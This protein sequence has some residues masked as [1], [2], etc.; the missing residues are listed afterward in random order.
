MAS[1][2][3]KLQYSVSSSTGSTSLSGYDAESGN[4]EIIVNETFGA[5]SSNVEFSLSLTAANLQSVFMVSTQNL[6]IKTNSTS[7]P[8]N[9][10]NLVA[11]IPLVWGTS[12]GYST[13]PFT[14]N[15]TA[16][17]ATCTPAAQLQMKILSN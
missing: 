2:T 11:G 6:T 5:G 13:C 9:T 15:V 3:N 17:Y 7:S 8:G 4:S 14:S 10:I 12:S 1:I 16:G